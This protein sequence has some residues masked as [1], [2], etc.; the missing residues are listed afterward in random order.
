MI[1]LLFPKRFNDVS[2]PDLTRAADNEGHAKRMVLPSAQ[3]LVKFSAHMYETG[4]CFIHIMYITGG[5]FIQQCRSNLFLS[6][7]Q[8]HK[9]NDRFV[10]NVLHPRLLLLQRSLASQ[11]SQHSKPSQ[12]PSWLAFLL[13]LDSCN[14]KIVTQIVFIT[15]DDVSNPS[16]SDIVLYEASFQ[17]VFL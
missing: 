13:W 16:T 9:K 2:F 17:C 8:I 15:L 7:I 3:D 1:E 4:G 14:K 6:R 5:C 12:H 11:S 10:K